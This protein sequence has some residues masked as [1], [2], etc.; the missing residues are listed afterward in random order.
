AKSLLDGLFELLEE[1]QQQEP[2][3]WHDRQRLLLVTN[4]YDE[5]EWVESS[6][7][8]FYPNGVTSIDE[9]AVLRRDNAPADLRGIRRGEVRD[10]KQRSVK[11]LVAPL[12]A[13]ERGHNILNDRRLAAFGGAVFFSRP[14]PVPDD[15]QATVRQLNHWALANYANLGLYAS[16][17]KR[18]KK[19]TLANVENE[20]YQYAIAQM[21]ELNCRAMSYK[22][23]TDDERNV[24]AWTQLVSIWQII[25][26]LVRGG[27]PCLVHFLDVKF[28]PQ[29][30]EGERDLATTSLLVG[31]LEALQQEIE[32]DRKRHEQTLA[33]SLYGAFFNALK[34]TQNFNYDL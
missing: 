30:A 22:Q 32:G 1:K 26:R 31:I 17:P 33:R 4:S 23:L 12:M 29:S 20:F 2:Q 18:G 7:R 24:L 13:L 19:L 16:I 6:L 9:I 15:W 27:V 3:W 28:A 11:I 10:V 25:G 8:E 5:A 21:L 14:M 34:A